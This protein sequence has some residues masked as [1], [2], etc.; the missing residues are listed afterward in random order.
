MILVKMTS[1]GAIGYHVLPDKKREEGQTITL[2]VF[3]PNMGNLNIIMM[4]SQTNPNR[5]I[6]QDDWLITLKNVRAMKD[7]ERRKSDPEERKL[8]KH[9]I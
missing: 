3:L 5:A 7:K 4:K 6:P 9:D 2:L 8:R 1:N